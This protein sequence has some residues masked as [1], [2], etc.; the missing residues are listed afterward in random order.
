MDLSLG[1]SNRTERLQAIWS[2]D[3]TISDHQP[4]EYAHIPAMSGNMT[5]GTESKPTS[6]ELGKEERQ[7][8]QVSDHVA[9]APSGDEGQYGDAPDGSLRAWLVAAGGAAAF[10]CCLG[11]ANSFGTFEEY[12]LSHQLHDKTAS[13]ISWIGSVASFLQFLGGLV[14]GPLFDLYGGFV[15]SGTFQC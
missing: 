9:M 7:V 5:Q 3:T 6:S 1:S 12:Y 10:F 13:Q 15:C 11:F 8:S 14:G 4:T 2:L